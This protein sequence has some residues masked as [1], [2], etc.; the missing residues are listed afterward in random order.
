VDQILGQILRQAV[1]ERLEMLD[2]LASHADDVSLES[3]ARTE[4][5][6]LTSGLRALLAAHEPDS[7]GRCPECSRRGRPLRLLRLRRGRPCTLWRTAHEH[8]LSTEPA[9]DRSRPDD[10]HPRTATLQVAA[11][12]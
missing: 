3:V 7:K 6:R 1:W 11:V 9:P 5:P 2:E 8:F 4:L 10:G 12:H